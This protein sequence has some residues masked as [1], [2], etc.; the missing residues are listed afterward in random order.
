MD[1][2]RRKEE[3]FPLVEM[4]LEYQGSKKK[5]CAEHNVLKST[6]DYWSTK[7]RKIHLKSKKEP[8][9]NFVMIQPKQDSPVLQKS[10]FIQLPIWYRNIRSY[11]KSFIRFCLLYRKSIQKLW[12]YQV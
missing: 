2:L 1:K 12:E 9:D 10:L 7:Y 5:F 6:F 3:M 11:P 8:E 4:Y